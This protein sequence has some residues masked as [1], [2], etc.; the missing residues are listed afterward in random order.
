VQALLVT[1]SG[2]QLS[3]K[4]TLTADHASSADDFVWF[5]NLYQQTLIAQ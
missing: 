2:V 5:V 3:Q 4:Q 1:I